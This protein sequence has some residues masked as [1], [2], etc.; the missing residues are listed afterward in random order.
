MRPVPHLNRQKSQAIEEANL[1]G[2]SSE[3]AA[4]YN[5]HRTTLYRWVK[6]QVAIK[7]ARPTKTF[8]VD[9][10][11]GP[12][13]TYPE[14]EKRLLEWV[15][16]MRR[17]RSKCV[18]TECLMI[19]GARFEPRLLSDRSERAALEYLRRFRLRN[20][21]SVRRI[22]H[23]G[24]K[25]RSEMENV[26]SAF[27]ASMR[28]STEN[29]S[30]VSIFPGH[31]KYDHVYN[32][33]Q[34][35]IYI[36]MNPNTTITFTGDKNVDV[37]QSMTENAFRASVF[38]CASATGKKMPP[39]IVFA[40]V[41]N[42]DV[43]QELLNHPLHRDRV[44]LTVQ[45]KA[46]CDERVMLDWI[47]EVWGPG[48][49]NQRLLLLDSLKTHKMAS[50]RTKLEEDYCSEVEFVPP[51]ITG[52]AQPMDVSVMR[53]FKS[54]CRRL[55]VNYH[56]NHDFPANTTARRFLMTQIVLLAW[57]SIEEKRIARGFVKAGLVPIGPREADGSFRVQ[58]PPSDPASAGEESETE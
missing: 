53:S 25:Q 35:S 51:G 47:D 3:L 43:H 7:A 56:I 26:A 21:L 48:A 23:R 20:R 33:D 41:P 29:N 46:Y 44:I 12:A 32:M 39:L 16:D 17:N 55:Y 57:E 49:S 42:A 45:R 2:V 13:I 9:T 50:V 11:R 15:T 18:T 5:I 36:D 10:K 30:I 38:L 24:T 27:G 34:T 37:V 28:W 8:A 1:R 6:G 52:L 4:K 58:E 40:G 54:R 22:T 19:M 31:S 14:L